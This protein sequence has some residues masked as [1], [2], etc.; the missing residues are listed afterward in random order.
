MA[1]WNGDLYV[2]G[3]FRAAGDH[4]AAYLA[5]W[6][7]DGLT[8][9]TF[10]T[11]LLA[12]PNPTGGPVTVSVDLEAPGPGALRVLDVQ[13]REVAR[14]ADGYLPGGE[15]SWIWNLR[16]GA[17]RRVVPGVYFLRLDSSGGTASA[18]LVV[19]P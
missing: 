18:R 19:L 3:R 15:R 10:R 7:A 1:V 14:L 13:G 2:A 9:P 17:G 8:R 4:P 12:G 5:C 16:D 11:R 6:H